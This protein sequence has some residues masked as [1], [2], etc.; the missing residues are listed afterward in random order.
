MG[1]VLRW[2]FEQS[3]PSVTPHCSP[4]LHYQYSLPVTASRTPTNI[5]R[6]SSIFFLHELFT[7]ILIEQGSHFLD[8]QSAQRHSDNNLSELC[9][10]HECKS[11]QLMQQAQKLFCEKH[12]NICTHT[13]LLH[14]WYLSFFST[15]AIFGSIFLHTKVRKLRQ[16]RFSDKSA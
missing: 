13:C 16:N 9:P 10:F 4:A 14:T 1:R 8:F 6:N 11:G 3:R 2:M 5:E 7:P 12:I 15:E